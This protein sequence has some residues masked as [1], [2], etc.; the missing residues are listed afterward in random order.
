MGVTGSPALVWDESDSGWSFEDTGTDH[1]LTGT[2]RTNSW[3]HIFPQGG[4]ASGGLILGGITEAG[5]ISMTI[6]AAGGA[7]STTD[8]T[9]SHGVIDFFTFQHDNAGTQADIA[10]TGNAYAFTTRQSSAQTTRLIIKAN[11][12]LHAT[13]VTAGSGDLDGVAL[14]AEDDVGLVRAYQRDLY[15]DMGVAMSKWDDTLQGSRYDLKRIG[16]LSVNGDFYNMQRMNSLLGGSIWQVFQ[17]LMG[18]AEVL[19]PEQKAMLPERVQR[20]L[21]LAGN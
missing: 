10:A 14:D 21:A 15:S 4:P 2:A 18:I 16:V 9:S 12:T 7:P 20:R 5:A 8:T 13:N 3:G 6:R 19:T 17:D 11:G 1:S